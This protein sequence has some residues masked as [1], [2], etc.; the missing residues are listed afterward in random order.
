MI[1]RLLPTEAGLNDRFASLTNAS[2][3]KQHPAYQ[4]E[5]EGTI[6]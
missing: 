1:I 4:R 3:Q 5:H 6:W 2:V